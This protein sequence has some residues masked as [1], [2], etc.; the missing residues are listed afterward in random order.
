[1]N[2]NLRCPCCD[3]LWP[4]QATYED[5]RNYMSKFGMWPEDKES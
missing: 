1:V 5:H 3:H 2:T 4:D